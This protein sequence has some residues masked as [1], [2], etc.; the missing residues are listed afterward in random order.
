MTTLPTHHE[1]ERALSTF[2]EDHGLTDLQDRAYWFIVRQWAMERPDWHTWKVNARG[3]LL[4]PSTSRQ[5]PHRRGVITAKTM[6][7]LVRKG[8]IE[9]SN[10][11]DVDGKPATWWGLPENEVLDPTPLMAAV[12]TFIVDLCDVRTNDFYWTYR[13]SGLEAPGDGGGSRGNFGG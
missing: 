10:T 13:V 9:R 11:R 7:A 4:P 3:Y 8:M 6:R 1:V 5:S 12:R 2:A